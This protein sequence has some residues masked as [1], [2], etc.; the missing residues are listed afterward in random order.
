MGSAEPTL[1]NEKQINFKKTKSNFMI[2]L[3]EIHLADLNFTNKVTFFRQYLAT[4]FSLN[5][6]LR[7]Y[8]SD[9]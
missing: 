1:L 3:D 8:S 4:A 5:G 9:G 6:E 2:D 7:V